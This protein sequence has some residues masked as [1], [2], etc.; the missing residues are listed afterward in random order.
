MKSEVDS[1]VVGWEG[2]AWRG[3][4]YWGL[5]WDAGRIEERIREFQNSKKAGDGRDGERERD[6]EQKSCPS[7]FIESVKS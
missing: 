7:V 1:E 6:E 3:M 4:G 5:G 2:C